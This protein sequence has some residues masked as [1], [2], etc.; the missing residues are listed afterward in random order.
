MAEIETDKIIFDLKARIE[1]LQSQ[2][3]TLLKELDQT[4]ERFEKIN[5]LYR[6][7]FPYVID[8][9]TDEKSAFSSV[10]KDLRAALKKGASIGRI[11]YILK[12]LYDAMLKE[13]PLVQ[14]K[15][16]GPG[17]LFGG[18]FTHSSP[19]YIDDFKQGYF[20][21]VN[22]L[23]SILESSYIKQLNKISLKID[24]SSSH[25]DIIAI[26]DELFTLLINHLSDV[27]ADREKIAAFVQEIVKRIL[28][29]ESV[30]EQSYEHAGK[31]EK[32]NEGFGAFLDKEIGELK[33]S[34]DVSETLE[35]LKAQ[36]TS[37]LSSI[38]NVLK[39]KIAK[40]K[41]I[42]GVTE[43][44]RDTFLSRFARLKTELNKATMHSKNLEIKLNQDPLTG[45]YNR[46]AYNKRIEDEFERF[47][48]YGAT[49][50]LLVIDADHFKKVND[51]YGHAIGDKCLQEIIKR[52]QPHVRKSDMLARYGGEE[53]VVV[54]P[55]TDGRGALN[56]AEKI[57]QTIEK[58]EFI[59]KDDTVRVTVSI[60]ASQAREG[61]TS[62]GNIFDRADTAVYKAKEAGRNRIMLN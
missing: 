7:Y 36:V 37:T 34:L 55:E 52:T 6:K 38:E 26:R 43:R 21:I 5:K 18:L 39:K 8:L 51:N 16:K 56:V 9:I 4:E 23:K 50:S 33:N 29:I 45:A 24:S 20:D 28:D 10:L 44:N 62:P 40:D 14:S 27:G 46:R 61:D 60:G 59:Y 30:I 32:E 25:V 53:F 42:K 49:F 48:R 3:S 47:L 31:L 1:K 35:E 13:E 58:I 11:E 17:S 41:A 22:N 12:Q 57:R 54:M 15:K 2:K 19:D